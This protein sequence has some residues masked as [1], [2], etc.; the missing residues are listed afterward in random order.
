MI[1]ILFVAH[2]N[3]TNVREQ[4]KNIYMHRMQ[5]SKQVV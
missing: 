5:Q 1:K 4:G 2:Y 3:D